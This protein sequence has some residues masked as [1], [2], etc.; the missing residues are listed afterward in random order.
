MNPETPIGNRIFEIASA[1]TEFAAIE[2][3]MVAWQV[4]KAEYT[5]A[6]AEK[7]LNELVGDAW[8]DAHVRRI[9]P[10]A[11]GRPIG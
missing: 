1:P 10:I 8:E 5:L 3:M 9:I 6:R 7:L 2:L 11:Q 4:A